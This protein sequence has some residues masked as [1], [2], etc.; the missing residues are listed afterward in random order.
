MT[1]I[2]FRAAAVL[3]ISSTALGL[4]GCTA[5][6]TDSTPGSATPASD[7]AGATAT[8]GPQ[9]ADGAPG[10]TGPAGPRGPSGANGMDG[11]ASA[12]G[13]P[14]AKGDPGGPGPTGAHGAAG[15]D[16]LPGAVGATGLPGTAGAAGLPGAAGADGLPGVAGADGLA[17]A[18][19]ADGLSSLV[20]VSNLP[21]NDVHCAGG[22][23]QIDVGIDA[24]RD[25]VLQASEIDQT[26][27]SCAAVN[28]KRVVFAT[29]QTFDGNLG[30]IAGADA[31]CMAA[32]AAVPALASKTFRAWVSTASSSPAAT[33]TSDGSFV[34]VDGAVIGDS[35]NNVREGT[36]M[37]T[38]TTETGASVSV[39]VWTGTDENGFN[40]SG[41]D[42]NGWTDATASYQGQRGN[43]DFLQYYWSSND[44]KD[45]DHH[46]ALYCFEQ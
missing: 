2:G 13:L 8:T 41:E 40:V 10:A 46:S 9:G 3:V 17:G 19:G 11:A 32:A 23:L 30:G 16:G 14:G 35:F 7:T 27:Y 1:M 43:T 15:A 22:G 39:N 24:N 28:R 26:T 37:S 20:N 31:K 6:T 18:P 44:W 29:S 25:G 45:C 38:I 12:Q 33:F 42:C 34:T 5:G 36:L 4:G 21:V